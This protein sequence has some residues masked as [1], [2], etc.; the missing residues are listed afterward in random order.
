MIEIYVTKI[1]VY[2]EIFGAVLFKMFFLTENNPFGVLAA[3]A[4]SV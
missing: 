3:K 1:S 4:M 2:T